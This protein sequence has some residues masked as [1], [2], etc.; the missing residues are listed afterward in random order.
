MKMASPKSFFQNS[1]LS[2]DSYGVSHTKPF[3]VTNKAPTKVGEEAR[4][5]L[6]N[7]KFKIVML[8]CQ[9]QG[10]KRVNGRL[11]IRYFQHL[12]QLYIHQDVHTIGQENISYLKKQSLGVVSSHSLPKIIMITSLTSTQGI[13]NT[14]PNFS[15]SYALLFIF[16]QKH[17]GS[18]AHHEKSILSQC[19][20]KAK[21]KYVIKD[22]N[23][24][25]LVK[26]I[27]IKDINTQ[28]FN[29]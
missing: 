22:T 29:I 25:K 4:S 12:Q 16:S 3:L 28:P 18:M 19:I 21:S 11:K 13:V 7:P 27:S 6:G 5:T 26:Y 9:L 8:K 23:N 17:L 10:R 15:F 1:R 14:L 20:K 2:R 24:I